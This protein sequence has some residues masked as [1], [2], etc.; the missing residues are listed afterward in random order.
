MASF[1]AK[2]GWKRLRKRENKNYRSVTF[3]PD[4]LE[5]IPKNLKKFKKYHYGI[6]SSQNRLKKAEK[7]KK[8][9]IS[10][11]FVLTRRVIENFKKI[12]KKFKKLKNTFWHHFKLKQVGK[13][14]ERE[15]IKIIVSFRPYPTRN[16][17]FQKTSNKI[18]KIKKYRY[19]IVL[20]K[21]RMENDET[22]R[23]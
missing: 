20:T 6:I 18:Q 22:E 23:K 10:F 15:K 5:E 13:G 16:K 7:K 2:I 4:R 21:N 1:Q 19:G 14:L 12:A 3:L 8:Q 9:K 11:R 17:K